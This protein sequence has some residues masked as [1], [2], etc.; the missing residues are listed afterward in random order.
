MKPKEFI[1]HVLINE[2]GDIVFRHPYLS[3]SLLA[4]GIE[5]LGKCTLSDNEDWHNINPDKSFKAGQGLLNQID[6]RYRMVD[7]KNELRNGFSHT[8]SPK[9][10]LILSE[11]KNGSSHFGKVEGRTILVAEIFY[12]DFI[13]CCNKVINTEF[14]PKN[15]MNKDFLRFG[16]N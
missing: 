16:N 13:K 8:L 14:E 9:F 6:E 4:I 5:F 15:K 10:G 7:L 2:L 11:L 12:E 1:E 3:F